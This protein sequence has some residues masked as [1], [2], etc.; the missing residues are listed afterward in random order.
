MGETQ[1]Y[2]SLCLS[3]GN[4]VQVLESGGDNGLPRANK[5]KLNSDK[6]EILL[7]GGLSDGL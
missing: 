3:A 7:L 4:A 5:L 2:F 1:L 6:I